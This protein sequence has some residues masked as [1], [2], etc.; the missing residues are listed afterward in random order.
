MHPMLL[1]PFVSKQPSLKLYIFKCLYEMD[2]LTFYL[3]KSFIKWCRVKV[4]A[5]ETM[6]LRHIVNMTFRLYDILSK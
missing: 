6:V 4:E 3:Q 5:R 1:L 2:A